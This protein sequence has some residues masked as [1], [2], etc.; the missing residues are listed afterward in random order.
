MKISDYGAV[1]HTN[2]AN[3]ER[4]NLGHRLVWAR[5]VHLKVDENMI[6]FELFTTHLQLLFIY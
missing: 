3:L 6:S 4:G 1:L 5:E 2:R